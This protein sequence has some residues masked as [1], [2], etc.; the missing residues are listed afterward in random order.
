VDPQ[1]ALIGDTITIIGEGFSP[2]Y[3]YND[4]IFPGASENIHPI[5][6][7]TTEKLLVTVPDGAQSG[8]ITVNILD[9]ETYN[10][11]SFA[12]K[13]PHIESIEP[14][15][16]Y[17][18]DTVT[19]TGENFRS[20]N[21]QR[22]NVRFSGSNNPAIV[23]S[24]TATTIRVIVPPD[25]GN[26]NISVLGYPGVAFTVKPSVIASISPEQGSAGDIVTINGYGF[27]VSVVFFE[28]GQRAEVLPGATSR[29]IRV[30]VPPGAVDG[31]IQV[32][33]T[34]AGEP[35]TITSAQTFQVYP[36][37]TEVSP[38]NGMPGTPVTIEGYSFRAD[39]S[40]NV[41]KFNGT[42]ATIVSAS[43]TALNVTAPAGF[44][45]GTI[46]VTVNGRTAIGPEFTLSAPGTPIVYNISPRSGPVG[47]N[48]ILE[49]V[50]FGAT[51]GENVVK[52]GGNATA[53]VLSATTTK[54]LVKVPAGAQTGPVT[55]T[56]DGKTGTGSTF[57]IEESTTPFIASV[58]PGAAPLGST[59]KI[60]GGNF[61]TAVQ[62][63]TVRTETF[64][65]FTV[66]SATPETIT[67]T[68]SNASLGDHTLY[69]VQGNKTSNGIP[70][71]VSGHPV[72]TSL[73]LTE[74]GPGTIVTLTG[75]EFNARENGNTVKF[76]NAV[77]SIVD[78]NDPSPS[79]IRVF[80]PDVA[81]GIY[82]VTVTAFGNT[83]NALS[84]TVK[85]KAAAVKNVFVG[86]MP[87]GDPGTWQLSRLAFDPPSE[88][89]VFSQSSTIGEIT[90]FTIDL[91]NNRIYFID[92]DG[93]CRKSTSGGNKQVLYSAA[94]MGGATIYDLSLDIASNT[95]FWSNNLGELVRGSLDGS[96]SPEVLYDFTNDG[97]A[98]Y[99]LT[100]VPE[101]QHIYFVENFGDPAYV[102]V[103][104]GT[105][106]G[107]QLTPLFD[108]A[109]GLE[110]PFDMKVDAA[111]N[112][113]FILDGANR[114]LRGSVEGTGSLTT[115]MNRSRP[116]GGISLDLQDKFVYWIEY[117]DEANLIAAVFRA[118]YD[119]SIIPGTDPPSAV[120]KVYAN[121]YTRFGSL[122]ASG[123]SGIAVEN[124][125]SASQRMSMS[126]PS[127]KFKS[128]KRK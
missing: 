61:S 127:I 123:I 30:V 55:V 117:T 22:N 44:A 113:L 84:F 23:V 89:V 109:D 83:S 87:T 59:I 47:S 8:P 45:T 4:V 50:E 26:G 2:G 99:G 60:N 116:I 39:P 111:E 79:L 52:F 63:I 128:L 101:D 105:A 24:G 6:G 77:A 5:Q 119:G 54:L 9:E 72:L 46:T 14:A 38:R 69:V 43:P 28:T 48:V 62:D 97:V 57:T 80:V 20:V 12:V 86:R 17:I 110:S 74:G 76:G 64:Q 53:T 3:E 31:P 40:E 81:P 78:A 91:T 42:T 103:S 85:P 88:T 102:K 49:G 15:E 73:S 7:S 82:N 90:S 126:F 25:A 68:V 114:I 11:P 124:T 104:R 27:N 29:S 16:A 118:R 21:A 93:I 34:I 112:T 35:Q 70:F 95:I 19:I 125:S 122:N 106:D 65:N 1:E 107:T 37:I 92:L 108:P 32:V 94:D 58:T 121:I 71:T 115:F 13:A 33:S 66:V 98:P 41:V 36:K 67:A 51:P 96:S 120:E 10:S 56:K 75:N 18:G 100:Y